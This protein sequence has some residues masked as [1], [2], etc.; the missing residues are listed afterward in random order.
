MCVQNKSI[1][2]FS[3]KSYRP[4]S[5][6]AAVSFCSRQPHQWSRNS[7][8]PTTNQ[9]RPDL[10]SL[11]SAHRHKR[12]SSWRGFWNLWKGWIVDE[13]PNSCCLQSNQFRCVHRVG[14]CIEGHKFIISSSN[15]SRAS[16]HGF[17]TVLSIWM[18]NII[19]SLVTHYTLSHLENDCDVSA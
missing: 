7:R 16:M 13:E 14:A 6:G 10:M 4:W 1:L 5:F 12:S 9:S 11:R 3:L 15:S 8:S 17:N 18:T 2:S 19:E